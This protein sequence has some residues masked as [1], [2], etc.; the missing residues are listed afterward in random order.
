MCVCH[1]YHLPWFGISNYSTSDVH[2]CQQVAKNKVV[3]SKLGALITKW[4]SKSCVCTV[5][6]TVPICLYW[7]A[8]IQQIPCVT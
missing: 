3:L 5:C 2:I 4:E 8:R 6:V 1:P 7:Y